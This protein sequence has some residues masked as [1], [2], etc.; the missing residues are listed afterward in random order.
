MTSST[1]PGQTT[2]AAAAAACIASAAAAAAAT[3]V[4]DAENIRRTPMPTIP[5]Y[6][7]RQLCVDGNHA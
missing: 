1:A 6:R 4:Y 5:L 2:A 3:A 7:T